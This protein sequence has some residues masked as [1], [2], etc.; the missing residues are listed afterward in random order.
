MQH[1]ARA[2]AFLAA[3]ILAA[4]PAGASDG[5][6]PHYGLNLGGAR[7]SPLAQI[8]TENVSYLENRWVYRTGDISPNNAHVFECAPLAIG[9]KLYIITTFSRLVVLDGA[10]GE[11]LWSFNPDPPLSPNETGAGVLA[12]RGVARWTDGEN[13][14]ILLPVRDGRLYSINPETRNPD[15]EFGNRGHINLRGGLPDGGR[16][17][18]LS[19]PPL[20]IGDLAIA[21]CG[22]NDS[23]SPKPHVPVRAFDIRTGEER[24][25]FNTIPQEGE[26]GRETWENESWKNRGGGNVWTIM[27]A[28]EERGIVYLPVSTPA[29]DF[30]GGDRPG[31]NLYTDSLVALKAETGK[32]LWHF[33]AVRHDLWDYD[34][35]AQP[36]LA[37]IEV[38]GKAIPAVAQIGKTGFIYVLNRITGEP[39]FPIEDRPVPQSDV[40]GE[41]SAQ[42][43]PF[44]LKPPAISRQHMTVDELSDLD[45]ET[46]A[47]MREQFNHYRSEGL[48]TPPSLKGTIVYPG[49]HGGGNWSGGAVDLDGM[50]YINTTEIAYVL[51][52]QPTPDGPFAYRLSSMVFRDQNGYPGNKP[53]WGELMKVDLNRGGIVWRNPLGEF[54]ELTARGIPVTG[55]ENFGGPAVTA[56]GLVLIASTMDGRIRAFDASNG[57]T[58]WQF[59]MK[60][61]GYAGT[62]TYLGADGKQYVAVCA[63]GGGKPGTHKGDYVYG[64]ALPD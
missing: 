50:L 60:A 27:S 18:F 30:Y 19:S 49:L 39:V 26:P 28:D 44:P 7:F 20:V 33:Q 56:G 6:W 53:P 55:Q 35:P 23:W 58:L 40:P 21:G 24:W 8:T 48:F 25:R 5:D 64:F 52:L 43:Q 12:S 57:A 15:P 4:V 54:D 16:Y 37:D 10:T 32:K 45:E 47:F 22:I 61:A 11:E 63:G 42:T 14:R 13:E 41:A 29:Y 34:L 31:N 17:L 62:V 9:G 38:E 51:R 59:Q 1:S 3:F 2:M 36:L 46:R